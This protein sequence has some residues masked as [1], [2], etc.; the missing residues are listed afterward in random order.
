VV[1]DPA[2]RGGEAFGKI[3]PGSTAEQLL[4]VLNSPLSGKELARRLGVTP[5]RIHQLVVKLHA[6]GRVRIGDPRSV[7]RV[8]ARSDDPAVLLARDE[9]RIL[10]A[11]PEGHILTS[12]PRLAAAAGMPTPRAIAALVRLKKNRLVK[13]AES[14]RHS[15]CY[16]LTARGSDHFQRSD[17]APKAEPIPLSVRSDR[18]QAV[19]SCLDTGEAR[20]RD[21]RDTLGIAHASINALLQY[22]KRKGLVRK[23]SSD[24]YAAYALTS[25]GRATLTAMIRRRQYELFRPFR[26]KASPAPTPP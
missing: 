22:L 4:R 9:E 21:L 1:P 24:L 15:G 3:V 7:L 17:A 19:L 5:Q 6:Q 20:I 8:V 11:F 26:T 23:T 14:A 25:D 18:V 10:S 12:A 13:H 16:S 2:R